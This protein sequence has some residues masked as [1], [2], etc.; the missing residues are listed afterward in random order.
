MVAELHVTGDTRDVSI[1][2]TPQ[3]CDNLVSEAGGP[4]HVCLSKV[5]P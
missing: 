4:L 3:V 5:S 1:P 2:V